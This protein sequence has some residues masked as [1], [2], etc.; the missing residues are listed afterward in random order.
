MAFSAYPSALNPLI[1]PTQPSP[2]DSFTAR[3]LSLSPSRLKENNGFKDF[4]E[5]RK[6]AYTEPVKFFGS[7]VDQSEA[8]L[9]LLDLTKISN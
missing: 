9:A 3:S 5:L 1:S 6:G 8:T 7:H 4:S 2:P